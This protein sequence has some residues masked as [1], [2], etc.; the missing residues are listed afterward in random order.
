MEF[1]RTFRTA[2][3]RRGLSLHS[4]RARLRDRGYDVSVATLSMW[5]SGARHPGRS[6]SFDV[7]RELEALTGLAEGELA[8]TLGPP[9]RV[10]RTEAKSY[11]ALTHLP[12]TPFTE[13]LASELCE[14]S[15]SIGA[16]LDADGRITHTVTRSLWQARKDGARDATVF[17]DADPESPPPE[18]RGTLGC[19]VVDVAFDPGLGLVRGTLR[20]DA[21]L[22]QGSVA[23]TE[24]R[25]VR[26]A[27]Y[28]Q[29]HA[30]TLVAP[31]RQAELTIYAVFDPTR[32]PTSCR[33]TI[34]DKDR[35]RSHRLPLNGTC[36][37]HTEFGF[38]PGTVTLDWE[39]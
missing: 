31:C 37:T 20:L 28:P 7:I 5:Q 10:R 11:A 16:V 19:S 2:V 32:V 25:A 13:E 36:V 30:L 38:G 14:R 1:A 18:I 8:A 6:V 35:E 34:E 27:G 29:E 17:F 24:R 23:L 26:P 15:G 22:A 33:V 3:Q 21:A 12:R 4:L 39:F 9:R